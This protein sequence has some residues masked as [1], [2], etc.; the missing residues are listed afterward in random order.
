MF[1]TT[2]GGD[3]WVEV[4]NGFLESQPRVNEVVIDRTNPSILYAG[5]NAGMYK[6]TNGG[7]SW[8]S[9]NSGPLFQFTPITFLAIDAVNPSTLYAGNF[10]FFGV[11]YKTTDGGATW[12]QISTG[13]P[14]AGINALAIDPV[15]PASIYAATSALGIL[16]S[17]DG[18][19]SWVQS[20]EGLTN[21]TLNAVAIDGSNP[22]VVYAG[23]NIGG[24]AFVAK[25]DPS[26]S[27]LDYLKNFGG[28]EH[29]D[30]TGVGRLNLVAELSR[31]QRFPDIFRRRFRRFRP[32]A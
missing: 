29:D 18:G 10:G 24:D 21:R 3:N 32:K 26:G 15:T 13:F 23:A 9:I 16:K 31:G 14:A 20:N 25:F 5:T 17:A 22:A 4:N 19:V 27:T 7:A 30:A 12:N 11:I 1:K 6:T 8:T 2:N 28:N